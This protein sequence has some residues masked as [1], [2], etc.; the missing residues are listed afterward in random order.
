MATLYGVLGCDKNAT[1]G[2]L[3]RKYQEL[4]LKYHPDK[5]DKQH[6]FSTATFLEIDEA[7][8]ILRDPEQRK[9]YDYQLAHMQL[10]EQPVV[11]ATLTLSDLDWHEDDLNYSYLCRCGGMYNIEHSITGLEDCFVNCENCSLIIH[12]K[13][14]SN[15]NTL[16]CQ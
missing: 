2:E 11:Y 7:W 12:I 16:D 14:T 10:T 8:K 9:L 4:V 3:K 13:Y 1:H 15:E 5:Q 6:S